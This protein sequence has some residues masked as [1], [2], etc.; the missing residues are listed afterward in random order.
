MADRSDVDQPTCPAC[1]ATL[2]T[3]DVECPSCGERLLTDE[4]LTRLDERMAA[5]FDHERDAAPAWAAVLTGL[6]LG[7]AIAPLVVY[8]AVIAVGDLPLS[9][10]VGLALAGWLLPAAY[11]GRF[12]TP[13]AALAR[14]LYLVVA[15]VGAVLV[16][17]AYDASTAGSSLVTRRT[18]LVAT[19]L[20]VPAMA[21]VLLARRVAAR[22]ARQARGEP[23]PIH[24][25]AGIEPA[26]DDEERD[27][28]P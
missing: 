23:G 3:L 22:A 7:I 12:P 19:L 27:D 18:G 26:G 5:A 15:G 20:A 14:G 21:A 6:A 25:R 13:S 11:L 1:G 24:E 9:V 8:S 10:L 16:A 2:E 17:L 28:A 4:Q